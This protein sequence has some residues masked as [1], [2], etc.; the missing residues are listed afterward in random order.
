LPTRPTGRG[1]AN[2]PYG[3]ASPN[4]PTPETLMLGIDDPLVWLAYVLCL[5]ATVLCVVY[6]WKN[7]NRGDDTVREEDV[8]WAKAEDKLEE[9]L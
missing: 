1:L 7:W 6:S 4:N 5:M 2:R 3:P 8:R 9:N